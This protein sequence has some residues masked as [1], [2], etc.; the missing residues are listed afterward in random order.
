MAYLRESEWTERQTLHQRRV[1]ALLSPHW[2]RR[3]H[4]VE[5]PV[6]DFL[7]EYYTFR[8]TNLCVWSPGAGVW[9]EAKNGRPVSEFE[10][11]RSGANIE[12]SLRKL[13]PKR[14]E[15]LN[16]V[17]TLL[18]NTQ[19]RAARFGCHGLH[20]WAMV[21]RSDEYR[22]QGMQRLR[23]SQ[24]EIAAVVDSMPVC[25]THFDA[26]RFFTQEARPL[27]IHQPSREN[28]MDLEQ[29]GCLHVNM[30]LYRWAYKF[31]PWVD[32][33]LLVDTF[34]LALDARQIDMKASPYD[35]VEY[36]FEPIRIETEAGRIEYEREQRRI[37]TKA[38]SLRQ[39]LRSALDG[40]IDCLKAK[41]K[42]SRG[43]NGMDLVSQAGESTLSV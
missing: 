30:D 36:G 29:R 23:L 37:A 38:I 15:S 35:L 39:R 34:E 28:R 33:E 12:V 13:T 4:G 22:Y 31:W 5:H 21:Y 20:E 43:E 11:S 17:R 2:K 26:F 16:W 41:E 6:F 14:I 40:I 25:C 10:W 24:S 8:S 27:N 42:N 7:F 18:K 19:E 32:S 1:E 3:S 9:L